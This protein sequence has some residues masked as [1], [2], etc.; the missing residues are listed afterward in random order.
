[1]TAWQPS[2]EAHPQCSLRVRRDCAR[3]RHGGNHLRRVPQPA[4]PSPQ[5]AVHPRAPQTA[6]AAICAQGAATAG[7]LLNNNK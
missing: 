1:M 5:P 4:L 2:S 6:W 7:E 3:L